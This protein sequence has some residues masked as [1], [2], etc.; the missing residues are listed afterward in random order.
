MET[1]A[2]SIVKTITWRVIGTAATG[3]VAFIMTGDIS[4]ASAIASLQFFT[5]TFLYFIHERVWNIISWGK[6]SV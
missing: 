4:A 6:K 3:A 1:S 5:N 2:R